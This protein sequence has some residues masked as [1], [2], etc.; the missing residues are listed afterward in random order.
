MTLLKNKGELMMND[1]FIQQWVGWT[2][3]FQ[4]CGRKIKK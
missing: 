1:D 4:N 2:F 3:P